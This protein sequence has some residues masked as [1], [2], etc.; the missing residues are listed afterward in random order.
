MENNLRKGQLELGMQRAREKDRNHHLGGR[1]FY[2]F[3]FD[4]NIAF[5]TTPLVLFH[6]KTD[7]ELHISSGEWAK[8]HSLIGLSGI[9]QDYEIRFDD[10]IGTFRYFR[11]QE[12]S[13]LERLG[14][15]HQ[16]FV[17][18]VKDILKFPD[19]DWKG[20]S[21]ECFY[22]ATF[23]QRPISVITARGHSAETLKE[24]IRIFVENKVLP[25]EPNYLSLFAVSNNQTRLELGDDQFIMN[26]AQL[27]QK[28]IRASVERA[29][30]IYGYND[31]HRFGMSDDDPK[32]LQLIYDEMKRLKSDY[33]QMSFFLIE[34]HNGDF[35]KHEITLSSTQS[36]VLSHHQL[37]LFETL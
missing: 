3:D 10:R 13:E 12:L 29:V 19:F 4:D 6:K 27:K 14:Y 37:S 31:H 33:P 32:N 24:G 2:F 16:I 26:T 9:Y 17:K 18:D 25:L 20:P 22:H 35:I 11:D 23:N 34:T 1:S 36:I 5:L 7:Q 15:E 28:A 8:A 30:E 21:W